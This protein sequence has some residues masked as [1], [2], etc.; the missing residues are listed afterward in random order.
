M[1]PE[2]R[3]DIEEWFERRTFFARDGSPNELL[4]TK[5]RAGVTISV[6]LPALNEE[7]TIGDICRIVRTE[8]V[9]TG[10]V[11]ELVVV[12]SGSTD[13]TVGVA[14]AAGATVYAIGNVL[15]ELPA[16]RGKGEVLWRSLA[17]VS[18]D[19]VVYLDADVRNFRSTFVTRLAGP[20]LRDPAIGLVKAFYERLLGTEGIGGGRVTELLARPLLNLFYPE[21]AGVIQPLAGEYA[22]RVDL[23]K[24]LPFV[25]GYGVEMGLLIDVV[26]SRGLDQLAQVDLGSREHR[27]R[28]TTE[29]GPMAFEIAKVVIDRG[30]RSARLKLDGSLPDAFVSFDLEGKHE[31]NPV[32]LIE[33]PPMRTYP[34]A[35]GSYRSGAPSARG[36]A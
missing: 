31:T 32:P 3:S 14:T 16:I 33:R 22:A 2:H 17:V 13:E 26:E 25:C 19:I 9:E 8:L 1:L 6:C 12:D 18:G 35:S 7:A 20:L 11:D 29:L 4:D 36:G 28:L 34:G 5:R 27:N 30:E 10:F 23:L 24:E 15:P 21:L